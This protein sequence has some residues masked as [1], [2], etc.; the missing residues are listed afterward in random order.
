MAGPF[1]D[2]SGAVIVYDVDTLDELDALLEQD[3]Y[4]RAPGVTIVRKQPWSLL[5]L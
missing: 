1:P 4:Y 3:P 5:D 2:Q